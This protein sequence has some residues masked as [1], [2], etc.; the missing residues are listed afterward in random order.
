MSESS[1][2]IHPVQRVR[3]YLRTLRL[4]LE[5]TRDQVH[6]TRVDLSRYVAQLERLDSMQLTQLEALAAA[7]RR[8]ASQQAEILRLIHDRGHWRR[9]KLRA[10]RGGGEYERAYADPDP[11]VSVVIPTYDNHVLL[12][13]RAI[14]SVLAQSHQ[15]FEILICGDAA[16][17]QARVA[18]ESFGDP[19][20]TF[21]NRLYRGPYPDDPEV[22]WRVAGVPPYN[23]AVRRA[24]GL[25]IAPLDDDDAFRPQHIEQLLIRAREQR[26]E[27]CYAR[28]CAHLRG[29]ASA[30]LGRFPPEQ[31]QFGLQSALY[32]AG[33]AEI[34]ELELA[35]AALGLPYDWGVCQRMMEADVRIG[36]I[37]DVSVDYYP[38]R[39][40]T[41]RWQESQ[42][43]PE[44]V[45]PEWEFVPE[46]FARTRVA[47]EQAAVGWSAKEVASAYREKW[48]EFLEAVQ[49]EGALGV[50]H[51]VPTGAPIERNDVLAQN[52]VL[53]FAYALARSRNGSGP[54]SVLD[55][56]GA[57]GHYY[58]LARRLFPELELDY[59]CRELPAV[60]AT[61]R[62]VLPEVTFHD[63]D[64]CFER[65]YDLVLA[66]GSL[67][68]EEDWRRL[69]R[70]LAGASRGW[71][72]L[73][74]V[75]IVSAHASF[76]VLQRAHAYG[77][78]TEYLGWVLSREELLRATSDSGLRLERELVL[79]PG[80]PVEGAPEA[81]IHAGFLF[82]PDRV[83]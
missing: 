55:H 62:E 39:Y 36:M 71:T 83:R 78:A 77:Y 28:I 1:S 19:R 59:H 64:V 44:D 81:F 9:A 43:G 22:R 76:V 73:T 46:G 32:H 6:A 52:A 48:P 41:R 12:A 60:C 74:R 63:T 29:G 79:L 14:P 57:L 33:L 25:W 11:L 58:V 40:W 56:G 51:E 68:Y 2:L 47:G 27:L 30:T 31:G 54:I 15:N 70:R 38:S 53:A 35:D 18:A 16:P 13:E 72:F 80:L 50:G 49:G 34:F 23:E 67:Q 10:L 61:G 3:G 17:D 82:R 75:P 24:R 37:D 42:P 20:I 66:S 7:Q 45:L 4:L 65:D 5:Q 21:S 26:L 69:L 8:D